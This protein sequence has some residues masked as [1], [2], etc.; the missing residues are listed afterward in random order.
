MI[1]LMHKSVSY[2]C[3]LYTLDMM[4]GYLFD[5]VYA[6]AEGHVWYGAPQVILALACAAVVIAMARDHHEAR[7]S[8]PA[9]TDKARRQL[10]E[11]TA[12]ITQKDR[13]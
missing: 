12:R 2:V 3:G 10:L 11:S 9:A 13:T 7:R 1:T 8:P 6:L 5:A 4:F